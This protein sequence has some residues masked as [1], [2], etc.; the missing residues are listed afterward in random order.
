MRRVVAGATSVA[1]VGGLTLIAT[2][3][4]SAQ[5]A[6]AYSVGVQKVC[7][8]GTQGKYARLTLLRKNGEVLATYHVRRGCLTFRVGESLPP[9]QYVIRHHAP[10]GRLTGRVESSGGFRNPDGGE[11]SATSRDRR[12]PVKKKMKSRG[13]AMDPYQFGSITFR[14]VGKHG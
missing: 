6:S 3:S 12:P 2:A 8:A 10:R 1:L 13:F 11:G 7:V 5:A 14:S 9:G 4:P